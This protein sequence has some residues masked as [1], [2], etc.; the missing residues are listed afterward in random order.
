MH[1]HIRINERHKLLVVISS[2]LLRKLS[3]RPSL[4]NLI[5]YADLLTVAGIQ[6]PDIDITP[7]VVISNHE[8]K[9]PFVSTQT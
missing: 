4:V 7:R 9:Y 6:F 3:S 1:P 5:A 8:T 2:K